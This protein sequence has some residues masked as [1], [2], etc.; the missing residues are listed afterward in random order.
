MALILLNLTVSKLFVAIGACQVWIV[1]HMLHSNLVAAFFPHCGSNILSYLLDVTINVLHQ[2]ITVVW[3]Q[4][5]ELL[6]LILG[7]V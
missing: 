6:S 7:R 3:S 2:A 4:R 1:W 5:L